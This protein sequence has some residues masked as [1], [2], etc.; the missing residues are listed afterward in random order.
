MI[1]RELSVWGYAV[2]G[3]YRAKQILSPRFRGLIRYIFQVF[4]PVSA[5]VFQLPW[6]PWVTSDFNC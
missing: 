2:D 4:L 1:K 5:P 3:W 6:A